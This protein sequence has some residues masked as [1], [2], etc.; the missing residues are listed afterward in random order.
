M[1]KVK[2][3]KSLGIPLGMNWEIKDRLYTMEAKTNL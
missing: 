2:T 3:K 1:E